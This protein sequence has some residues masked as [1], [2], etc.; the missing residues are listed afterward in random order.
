MVANASL[1]YFFIHICNCSS[2]QVN[3]NLKHLHLPRH[4]D[5]QPHLASCSQ[6][7]ATGAFAVQNNPHCSPIFFHP[8]SAGLSASGW[9]WVAWPHMQPAWYAARLVCW[10]RAALVGGTASYGLCFRA[11]MPSLAS[12]TL[13]AVLDRSHSRTT[14]CSR[15]SRS[16]SVRTGGYWLSL[17]KREASGKMSQVCQAVFLPL[18]RKADT[19]SQP[20][21]AWKNRMPL[22]LTGP[23]TWY[24]SW[25]PIHRR[26]TPCPNATHS[27]WRPRSLRDG[28]MHN[29]ITRMG[30]IFWYTF[31]ML[32]ST[33]NTT[34]IH[35]KTFCIHFLGVKPF[36]HRLTHLF[37]NIF[38]LF[39]DIFK[40]SIIIPIHF[41]EDYFKSNPIYLFNYLS[42]LSY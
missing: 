36:F 10:S 19:V 13:T 6:L 30:G 2:V 42:Y 1:T 28:K 4:S 32:F 9:H 31:S 18:L 7:C 33:P 29:A 17:L 14:N 8:Q 24:R 38:N 20:V 11:N 21:K 16:L 5:L 12:S 40:I 25:T 23:I 3:P 39:I 37:L 15:I 22:V 41:M 27:C 35:W 34:R 26:L